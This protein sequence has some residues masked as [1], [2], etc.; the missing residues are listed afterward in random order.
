MNYFEYQA[1][2]GRPTEIALDVIEFEPQPQGVEVREQTFDRLADLWRHIAR[3]TGR[4]P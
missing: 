4:A 1:R 2:Q 3:E